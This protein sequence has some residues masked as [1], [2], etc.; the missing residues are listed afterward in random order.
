MTPRSHKVVYDLA[1][2][3]NGPLWRLAHAGMR[4]LGIKQNR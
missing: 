3:E 2:D 4:V 1:R